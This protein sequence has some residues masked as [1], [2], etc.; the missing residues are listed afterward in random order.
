MLHIYSTHTRND[1]CGPRCATDKL[2]CQML[3]YAKCLA[4]HYF[5]CSCIGHFAMR[6]ILQLSAETVNTKHDNLPRSARSVSRS[7]RSVSRSA[8]S[9][10]RSARL[11]ARLCCTYDQFIRE[12]IACV[13]GMQLA[14]RKP[15]PG[16]RAPCP[17]ARA[18]CPGARAPCPG[19]R[20][21]LHTYAAHMI[22]LY[23]KS[24]C[25]VLRYAK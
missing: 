5:N 22:G 16:A 4:L 6:S 1:V 21:S 24:M 11:L 25:E 12:I 20:A 7:A 18:P 10:L 19:A 13:Q 23:E 2:L 8:R 9:V 14:C 15:F 17:G 3:R